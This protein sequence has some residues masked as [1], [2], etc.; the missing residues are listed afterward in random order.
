MYKKYNT[1]KKNKNNYKSGPYVSD[2][3]GLNRGPL[4]QNVFIVTL[5]TLFV[6]RPDFVIII[7]KK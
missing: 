7:Y 3:A 2:Q 1:I 6:R 5:Y 4:I